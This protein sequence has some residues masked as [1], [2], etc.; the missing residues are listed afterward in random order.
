MYGRRN[1]FLECFMFEGLVLGVIYGNL[2]VLR[3]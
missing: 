1:E 2:I 3:F